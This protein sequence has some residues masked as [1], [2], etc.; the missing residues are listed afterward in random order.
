VA[1]IVLAL[2]A[3]SFDLSQYMFGCALNL[4]MLRD[5]MLSKQDSIP[6]R[7]DT[8]TRPL[9]RMVCS[10]SLAAMAELDSMSSTEPSWLTPAAPNAAAAAAKTGPTIAT[11]SVMPNAA[12][13]ITL[14]IEVAGMIGPVEATPPIC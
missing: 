12:I 4:R 3:L 5:L 1:P 14:A 10:S 7:A 8:L 9:K 13:Q 11:D 6:Y 2:L